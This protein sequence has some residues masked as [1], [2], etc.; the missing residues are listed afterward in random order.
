ML[1]SVHM[2]VIIIFKCSYVMR[3]KHVVLKSW[4]MVGKKETKG[5]L[6]AKKKFEEL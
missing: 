1:Q 2:H 5:F 4:S 6:E 3:I